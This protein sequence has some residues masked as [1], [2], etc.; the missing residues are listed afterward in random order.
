MAHPTCI[1]SSAQV[2]LVFILFFDPKKRKKK[3]EKK[4]TRNIVQIQLTDNPQH[5]V[6]GLY[7]RLFTGSSS[8]H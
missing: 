5:D 6:G 1:H 7:F 3:K 4:K 8:D 2:Q